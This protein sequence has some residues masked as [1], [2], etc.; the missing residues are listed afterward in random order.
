MIAD[1]LAGVIQNKYPG[2]WVKISVAED[3]E[4]G[5]EIEYPVEKNT[6]DLTT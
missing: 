3:D 5:T 2:R 4:N 6:D 1:D